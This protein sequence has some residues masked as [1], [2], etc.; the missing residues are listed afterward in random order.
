LPKLEPLVIDEITLADDPDRWE[1]LGFAV[2]D[3]AVRIGAVRIALTGRDSGHGILG[4]TLRGVTSGE[5]DGLPTTSSDHPSAA[6]VSGQPPPPVERPEHPNGVIAIDHIVAMSPALD[7][8]VQALQSAGLDL[9]R[10]RELPT[11]AGAPRQAFFRLGEVI[12]EVIQEPSEVVEGRSDGAD[13]PARFWGL[14]LLTNDLDRT[15]KHLS[16]HASEIRPAVQ[17]RRR[18]AT[19][20]RSAALAVPVALMSRT[21]NGG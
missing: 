2:H 6:I 4:W 17:P 13:R 16:G 9:R 15:V 1:A 21:E 8:S 5:L 20:R 14:A 7:R 12:L 18:I 10:I 11:P 19:I 3:K